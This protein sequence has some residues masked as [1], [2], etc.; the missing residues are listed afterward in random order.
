MKGGQ[1]DLPS[2]LQVFQL[3]VHKSRFAPDR[4]QLER[5]YTPY[6]A[7]FPP[8]PPHPRSTSANS[9]PSSYSEIERRPLPGASIPI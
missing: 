5:R 1:G 2:I 7:I 4:N 3:A 6:R 9:K 8:L